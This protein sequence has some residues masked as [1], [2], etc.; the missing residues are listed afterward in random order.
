[1]LSQVAVDAKGEEY[2]RCLATIAAELA[3]LDD[4]KQSLED[5]PTDAV[6]NTANESSGPTQNNLDLPAAG[7]P[8]ENE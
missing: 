5:L 7:L 3:A 8:A 1:M 4:N 2:T 6:E